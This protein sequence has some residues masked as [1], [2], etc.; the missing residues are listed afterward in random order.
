MRRHALVAVVA[1]I[2]ITVA[3]VGP[4]VAAAAFFEL[5]G[6]SFFYFEGAKVGG[7]ISTTRVPVEATPEGPGVWRIEIAPE[8]FVLPE[9]AY[10]SGKRAV[11]RL[12]AP[13]VGRLERSEGSYRCVL[14]VPALAFVDGRETGIPMT[15]EFTTEAASAQAAGVVA[16]RE[17]SRIDPRSGQVQ[18]V[19]AGVNPTHAASAPGKPF[20]VVLSGRFTGIAF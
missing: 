16:S 20:Y 10:P 5:D 14:N 15:F 2:A 8:N 11:W 18:L 19:A 1:A 9:I 3:S 13:A 7:A 4:A 12:S 6:F 17:G